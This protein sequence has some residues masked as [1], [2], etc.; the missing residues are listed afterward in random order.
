MEVPEAL[1]RRLREAAEKQGVPLGLLV[2]ML[3]ARGL[4]PQSRIEAYR[5]LFEKYLREARKLYEKGEYVQAGEKLWGAVATL[6]DIIG[7]LEG[8]P[9]Y[10]H[11][12][13]W[14]IVEDIVEAT[15]DPEYSTLF[16]L[17]E[18]LRANFYHAFLRPSSFRAHWEGVLKLIEGLRRYLRERHG[19]DV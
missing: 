11:S 2:A 18:R 19:L 5:E 14:E 10:S 4:D 6:L 9:H 3:L 15:G 16:A 17:A 1:A 7:E 8:K 13:Y 12:D